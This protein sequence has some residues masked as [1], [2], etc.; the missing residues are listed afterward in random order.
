MKTADQLTA[1]CNRCLKIIL[2][3]MDE[4]SLTENQYEREAIKQQAKHAIWG[5]FR[6]AKSYDPE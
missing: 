1:E 6:E 4:I 3:G 2:S 5:L